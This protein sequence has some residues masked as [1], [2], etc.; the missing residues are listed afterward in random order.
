MSRLRATLLVAGVLCLPES[1]PGYPL[2]GYPS[3][4]IARLDAQQRVEAG[5]LRG[6]KQPPGALLVTDDVDLRLLDY[7]EMTLPEPDPA[8]TARVVKLLGANKSR[9]GV[10]VLDVSDPQNPRYAEHK[11]DVARNPGSVGKILVSLAIFQALADIY[12]AD[13]EARRRILR[14]AVITADE[15]HKYDSHP[16]RFW[17]PN[18]EKLARRPL[19]DGDSGTLWTYLDWMMSPSSNAAAGMLM[20][21]L[22]LLV[23][24]GS[25]YPVS[26]VDAR[27][28]FEETPKKELGEQFARA[29]QEPVTRNGLSLDQLRQGSF[30]TREGKRRV[31]GTSSHATARELMHLLLRMEQGKL[32]D[33]FSSREIKRLLYVTE[34]RIRYASSPA[35]RES[36]V[37][38]KSGSL[39]SCVEEPGFE[40]KKYHGN[41]R[42]FM[43][44]IAI[45]EHPS[46]GRRLHYMAAVTSNVLRRNSAVD[47]Q[48]LATRIHRIIEAAH[49]QN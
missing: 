43:N 4:G 13:L 6:K 21:H 24:F 37:Y 14:E 10:A 28:Y 16:V 45:V 3:T 19:R 33:A 32:V 35:L 36:A 27:R 44:S 2:D 15:F 8:F 40:C 18:S 30:F 47:H 49:P 20:K 7:P 42:N 46:A 17:D 34:R 31:P 9:Y 12:P 25:Q 48:T 1:G 39:Y 23:R 29:I 38:F 5:T 41:K 22:M 11:G 26:E